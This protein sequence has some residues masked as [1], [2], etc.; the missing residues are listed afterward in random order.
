MSSHE[1]AH[2]QASSRPERLLVTPLGLSPGVVYS[3]VRLTRPTTLLVITSASAEAQLAVALE[4][5][6]TQ[7]RTLVRL[8]AD[9]H[10][11]FREAAGVLDADVHAALQAADEVLVNITGGTTVMQ[12]VVQRIAETAQSLGVPT[13]RFALVDRRPFEAQRADPYVLGEIVWLDDQEA[14]DATD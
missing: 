10:A 7:P 6:A 9:P 4:K 14:N 13:R 1:V 3:A 8:M 11:G 12:Y 5:A 2:Q